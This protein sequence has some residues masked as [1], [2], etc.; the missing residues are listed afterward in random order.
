MVHDSAATVLLFSYGTLQDRRVQIAN[1]GRELVG[2]P[3]VLLGYEL[4]TLEITDAD[5]LATS[6]EQ[7]HPILRKSVGAGE[8]IRGTVF[9]LT[10]DELAAADKYEVPDYQRVLVTLQSGTEAYV[11]VSRF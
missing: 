11:Y 3:D 5:V 2:R 9:E 6:G 8:A 7:H 1:F 4:G 10:E